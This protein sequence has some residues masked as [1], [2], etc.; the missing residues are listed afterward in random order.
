MQFLYGL[1]F[2]FSH[3]HNKGAFFKT[4]IKVLWWKCNQL[5]FNLPTITTYI[6]DSK[7]I[8]YPDSS[9]SG[10]VMYTQVP[11]YRE[12]LFVHNFLKT[13]DVVLD[14][15]SHQ[16]D[17]ALLAA[18]KKAGPIFAFEPTPESKDRL[19]ANIELNN[20]QNSIT[21]VPK[22]VS[23]KE[24][25]IQFNLS[26]E[27]EVNSVVVGT[28]QTASTITVPTTSL[29]SF[30]TKEKLATINFLK[31]D[32]E[33]AE[34]LVLHGAATLFKNHQIEL[35]LL[36]VN[37]HAEQ[38]GF[39]FSAVT[40]YFQKFEYLLFEITDDLLLKALPPNWQPPETMNIV[41]VS[42][43]YSRYKKYLAKS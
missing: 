24:G 27:S 9:F 28:T 35:V 19:Q 33:G 18:D 12:S 15:G 5:F 6:G 34:M 20:Y 13:S 2:V 17:F 23:D 29:D 21:L 10:L 40:A 16:G 30:A 1:H 7:I 26:A 32:V 4:L 43:H 38:Y 39:D 37:V 25:S 22:A 36:E 41:A 42:T 3:P 8:C 11:E 14:V 31:I